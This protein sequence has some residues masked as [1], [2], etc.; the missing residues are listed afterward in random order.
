ML[1]SAANIATLPI[2]AIREIFEGPAPSKMSLTSLVPDPLPLLTH[3]SASDVEDF[4]ATKSSIV[5][6]RGVRFFG[7]DPAGPARTSL[8]RVV[9]AGVPFV[10][11][12][13]APVVLGSW[14][15]KYAQ[16]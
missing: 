14:A 4:P 1:S 3:S 2:V 5:P 15:L 9:P 13:S 10:R 7:S 8:T 6:P 12:S 16:W 11:Q